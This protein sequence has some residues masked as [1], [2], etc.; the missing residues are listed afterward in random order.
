MSYDL[1]VFDPK[2]APRE[3]RAFLAWYEEQ[4]Q[5]SEGHTSSDPQ[6]TS[7]SLRSWLLEMWQAFPPMNGP[8]AEGDLENPKVTDYSIGRT[9]IYAA[10]ASSQGQLA[11]T[12]ARRLAAQH[13]VGF[14]DASGGGEIVFP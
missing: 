7:T 3:Q 14:F 4:T 9:I 5:W 10:F 11:Y 13:S 2:A 1:A 12:A 6:V 8:F